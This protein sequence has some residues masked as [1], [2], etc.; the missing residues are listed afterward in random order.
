MLYLID[1]VLAAG[2]VVLAYPQVVQQIEG[3]HYRAVTAFGWITEQLR[4][5]VT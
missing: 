4:D 2:G 1:M 5:N 3:Q